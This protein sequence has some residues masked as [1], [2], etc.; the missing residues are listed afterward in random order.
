MERHSF[1]T[2]CVLSGL[3]QQATTKLMRHRNPTTTLRYYH[4]D[5]K[6]I[7]SEYDKIKFE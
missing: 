2:N 4:L 1:A 3:S 6:W 5:N 7:K